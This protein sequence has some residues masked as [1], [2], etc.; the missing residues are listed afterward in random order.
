MTRTRNATPVAEDDA[1]TVDITEADVETLDEVETEAEDDTF[2]AKA[3]ASELGLDP[4]AFR[5]WLRNYTKERANKGGR[6]A[7]TADR[8]SELIDAYN[9]AHAPAAAEEVS[10]E[11]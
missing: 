1:D 2:S 8:K 4:K 5:R 7:F 10:T 6:W 3:L 9:A 11:A